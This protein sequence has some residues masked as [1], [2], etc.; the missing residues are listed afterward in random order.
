M[1]EKEVSDFMAHLGVSRAK[2]T[3]KTYGNG[4]THL[5]AYA[6]IEG[7]ESLA[8]VN[9]GRFM[10]YL[11]E[12]GASP[13]TTG[14]Y[15]TA[16]SQLAEY[17]HDE[18]TL[19]NG[20][21]LAFRRRLNRVRGKRHESLPHVPP[22]EVFQAVL[23]QVHRDPGGTVRQNMIRLR[24]IAIMETLRSTGCR[25]SEAMSLTRGDLR[26]M[27]ATIRGKGGKA[28]L[29]F[30]DHV[31]WEAIWTYLDLRGDTDRLAP[32]FARHDRKVKGIKPMSTTSVRNMI[33][34]LALEAGLDPRR[35]S[36]HKMRHRFA[37]KVLAATGNLAGVQ[38]LLGHSSPVTTR[39]Y[40][41]LNNEALAQ[42][43]QSVSL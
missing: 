20:D 33:D 37:T 16:V 9:P 2:A 12:N 29:I 17:C 6:R 10:A 30:F 22:E 21:Y 8:Q 41:K 39:V 42:I 25:V 31:A 40:A 26:D 1:I 24:N 7:A 5:L 34:K 36:P 19:R 32:V 35:I 38:D 14:V 28:R 18:G 15:M 4:L 13:V 43:H 3:A 11:V 23:K 27:Q